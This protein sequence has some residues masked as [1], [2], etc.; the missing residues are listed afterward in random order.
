MKKTNPKL[1]QTL[2][3]NTS[4]TNYF[5]FPVDGIIIV[6]V[7]IYRIVGNHVGHAHKSKHT[8]RKKQI[9]LSKKRTSK[10]FKSFKMK[11]NF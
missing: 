6:S 11:H 7:D 2:K 8:E 9:D 3:I 4:H 10:P 5:L 1:L